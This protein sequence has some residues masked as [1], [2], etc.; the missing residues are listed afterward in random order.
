MIAVSIGKP[1]EFFEEVSYR[2]YFREIFEEDFEADEEDDDDG[3]GDF[4]VPEE[5]LRLER[6][7]AK[8]DGGG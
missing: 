8:T 2:G 7:K 6:E 3:D 4:E 1:A 5:F